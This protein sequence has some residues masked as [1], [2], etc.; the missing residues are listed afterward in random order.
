MRILCRRN[1][2]VVTRFVNQKQPIINDLHL[3]TY[4]KLW[5]QD[6]ECTFGPLTGNV[7]IFDVK[8]WEHNF[9]S[10]LFII[11]YDCIARTVSF[12]DAFGNLVYLNSSNCRQ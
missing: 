12:S 11:T 8:I 5:F 3:D 10:C 1:A 4:K 7:S 6:F 2:K 9:T